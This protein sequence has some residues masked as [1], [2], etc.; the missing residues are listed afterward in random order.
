MGTF[1]ERLLVRFAHPPL[2][3]LRSLRGGPPAVQRSLVTIHAL[4]FLAG[5]GPKR[6]VVSPSP[7]GRGRGG[8]ERLSSLCFLCFFVAN[9]RYLAATSLALNLA[10]AAVSWQ[11]CWSCR[12]IFSLARRCLVAVLTFVRA[13]QF[14]QLDDVEAE[15]AFDG[16]LGI[17]P[18]FL[19]AV[20][21]R[22]ERFAPS[23]PCGG[24][25]RGRRPC[26][27]WGN[28]CWPRP[29]WRNPRRSSVF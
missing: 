14:G 8:H 25:N 3:R 11:S 15:R 1:K 10:L 13:A 18:H 27:C 29:T 12:L 17:I 6:A 22:A 21:G 20:G 26:S 28:R 4:T 24:R 19:Q 9:P 2:A 5:G 7:C 23:R 16:R